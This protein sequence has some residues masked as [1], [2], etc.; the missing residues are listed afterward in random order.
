MKME[1]GDE[2]FRRYRKGRSE[3]IFR[4]LVTSYS[5][6]VLATARRM[7]GEDKEAAN[8]VC[9]QVFVKLVK[10]A[11]ELDPEICLGGWLYRQACRVAIDQ[12]RT[13]QRRKAREEKA[14]FF[15]T[16]NDPDHQMVLGEL[17][18]ALGALTDKERDALVLRYLEGRSHDSVGKQLGITAEAARKRCN[19]ALESLRTVF[20]KRSVRIGTPALVAVLS[21]L[22]P[23]PVSAAMIDQLVQRVPVKGGFPVTLATPAGSLVA[24]F[25]FS[26]LMAG[27]I[28]LLPPLPFKSDDSP[29]ELSAVSSERSRRGGR[30]AW[31]FDDPLTV[32]ALLAEVRRL[33]RE[34]R[35]SLMQLRMEALFEA[36]PKEDRQAYFRESAHL[37]TAVERSFSNGHFLE[38]WIKEH[39]AEAFDFILAEGMISRDFMKELGMVSRFLRIWLEDDPEEIASWLR[40]NWNHPEL[41]IEGFGSTLRGGV[42]GDLV[43]RAL[44]NDGARAAFVLAR[45]FGGPGDF[46]GNLRRIT[47]TTWYR[48]DT[49]YAV[50]IY[51]EVCR[52]PDPGQREAIRKEMLSFWK[53]SDARHLRRS[54]PELAPAD[55]IPAA[56]AVLTDWPREEKQRHF[57]NGSMRVNYEKK[58]LSQGE[59]EALLA[60]RENAIRAAAAEA[61]LPLDEVDRKMASQYFE[62]RH[63]RALTVLSR[64]ERGAQSD[65]VILRGIGRLCENLQ[66]GNASPEIIALQAAMMLSSPEQRVGAVR[67]VFHRLHAKDPEAAKGILTQDGIPQEVAATLRELSFQFDR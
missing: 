14:A 52:I 29:R 3:A 66:T 26:S 11:S 30:P 24:G 45:S 6:M 19:R 46:P 49:R 28:Y 64:L 5:P 32:K 31:H 9:Q 42:V 13:N 58:E 33:Y 53:R 56:L 47:G 17:D 48:T 12:R 54:L 41:S 23:Q 62:E 15:M 44:Q 51:Q 1:R 43:F 39:P 8:D 40:R 27:G 67:A 50:E 20:E 57:A 37:L 18:E 7:L 16:M 60:S 38:I 34:P 35:N 2:N 25:L 4:N 10:K 22:S 36:L 65:K 63:D 59:W 21:G 55:R 61:G